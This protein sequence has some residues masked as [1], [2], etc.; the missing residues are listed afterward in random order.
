VAIFR[1]A[2]LTLRP[3]TA[4]DAQLLCELDSDPEVMRYLNGGLATPL[5]AI[6]GRILPRFLAYAHEAEW[7]GVWLAY[8]RPGGTFAGWF[9]LRPDR[10]GRAE[11][12]YRLRRPCWGRGLATEGSRALLL[13]A[14]KESGVPLVF[15]TTYEQNVASRRVLE[16]LGMTLLRRFRPGPGDASTFE[17]DGGEPWPGDDLEYAITAETWSA[18]RAS[19][20]G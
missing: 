17:P 1:T 4:N 10:A 16:N 19:L 9:S 14:F 8:E 6:A 2:R 13:H 12:G 18:G 11:L 3:V 20:P 7:A 15:A 5:V